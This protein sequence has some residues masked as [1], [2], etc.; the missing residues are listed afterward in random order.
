MSSPSCIIPAHTLLSD[1]TVASSWTL[2]LQSS[3]C[4]NNDSVLYLKY[5]LGEPVGI[6]QI[7]LKIQGRRSEQLWSGRTI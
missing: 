1:V 2:A 6:A 4:V 3:G 5:N 7:S